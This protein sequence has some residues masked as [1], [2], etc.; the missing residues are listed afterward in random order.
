[1]CVTCALAPYNYQQQQHQLTLSFQRNVT[2]MAAESNTEKNS[3]FVTKGLQQPLADL[4]FS[5][6]LDET[7]KSKDTGSSNIGG[8][9]W[10]SLES[11][12]GGYDHLSH[13]PDGIGPASQAFTSADKYGLEPTVTTGNGGARGDPALGGVDHIVAGPGGLQAAPA[14]KTKEE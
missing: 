10:T 4:G 8:I 5:G 12:T 14:P 2:T 6:S 3:N 11:A 13:G 1:M 9:E 7:L